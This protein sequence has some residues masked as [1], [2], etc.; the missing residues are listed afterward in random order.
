MQPR[1]YHA[2]IYMTHYIKFMQSL[3]FYRQNANE[4]LYLIFITFL[5]LHYLI[6]FCIKHTTRFIYKTSIL[7]STI[8]LL[9]FREK[10]TFAS[11]KSIKDVYISI[12]CIVYSKEK[13]ILV[14]LRHLQRHRSN[15][16]FPNQMQQKR[17][18]RILT[19]NF[20]KYKKSCIH[21]NIHTY[22][23][24]LNNIQLNIN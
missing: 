6:Q 24:N 17:E 3:Y 14:L 5:K 10:P 18:N 9:P 22:T 12:R 2:H 20:Q 7:F 16:T 23:K 4:S 11:T 19:N 21:I 8:I 1:T 15:Y 13:S